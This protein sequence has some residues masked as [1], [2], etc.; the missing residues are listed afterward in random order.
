MSF[1]IEN[2][3][4]EARHQGIAVLDAEWLL[5]HLLDRRLD[6]RAW[7]RAH[8]TDL[9]SEDIKHQFTLACQQRLDHVPLAYLIGRRGFYGLEIAVDARVLD[10]RPDTETLVDWAVQLIRPYEFSPN[11]LDLGTGSGAIA[12]AIKHECPHAKVCA[13]DASPQALTVASTNANRLNLKLDL[14]VSNWFDS[15]KTDGPW[16]L[17]VSNPP[18]IE[19]DDPHLLALKHEPL[20]ALVSGPDGLK[21]LRH[22]IE[23]APFYL[24]SKGW[25][26]LEHGYDQADCVAQLLQNR[27]FM[28]VQSHHDLAGIARCTGGMWIAGC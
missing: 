2:A 26:L 6:D 14:R 28:Q 8:Q 18:Y 21:D 17:I 24:A 11:V 10:P 5:L 19:E 27:G 7:L 3:L 25:L 23:Q 4:Q 15:I 20:T 12:L 16:H 1:T 9:L 22:I 13:V